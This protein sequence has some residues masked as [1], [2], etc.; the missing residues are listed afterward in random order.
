MAILRLH[1]FGCDMRIQANFVEFWGF[2]L[3]NCEIIVMI[4]R[5]RT[6]RGD[7]RF[8]WSRVKIGSAIS[9]VTTLKSYLQ[10]S[11]TFHLYGET[12]PVILMLPNFACGFPS[13]TLSSVSDFIF[14]EPIVFFGAKPRKL[15][16]P[17]D[18]KGNLYNTVRYRALLWCGLHKT[19]Y[20]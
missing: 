2:D 3:W 6:S 12:P 5:V 19:T 16:V 1:G 4:P 8:E 14:I 9:S 17:N 13:P 15:A 20:M 18:L 10:K 11:E 7:T